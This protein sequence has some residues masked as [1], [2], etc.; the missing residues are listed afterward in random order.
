[1]TGNV[2]EIPVSNNF[3]LLE[4]II[5]SFQIVISKLLK[6]IEIV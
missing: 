3:D 2:I 4:K 1:V 6:F 5:T